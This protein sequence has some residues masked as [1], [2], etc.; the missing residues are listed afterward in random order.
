MLLAWPG[1]EPGTSTVVS[2]GDNAMMPTCILRSVTVAGMLG[3]VSLASGVRAQESE[4][5]LDQVPKAVMDSAKAKFPG[6]VIREASKET[7]NGKTV[8][9]L[10]MTDQNRKMDVSFQEDGTLVLVETAIPETELPPAAMRAVVGKYPG[11]RIN[12]VESVKQGPRV[13]RGIDYYEIHLTTAD[14]KSS[15]VE[16]D[17]SGKILKTEQ[18]NAEDKD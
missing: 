4:I 3:L 14:K 7:E 17:A 8:I 1:S 10:E 5:K 18:K 12:L 11:A 13:K 16:V 6:A 9:E 15:E 2:N